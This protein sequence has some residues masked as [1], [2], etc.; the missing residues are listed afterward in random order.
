[1]ALQVIYLDHAAATPLDE[2]VLEAMQPYFTELF[3]NP[4]SPYQP[5]LEVRRA[6][7]DAKD[8]IAR[9]IG[10]KG[11]ELVM[12]AGATESINLAFSGVSGHVVT[13]NIE[14]D[15]VLQAAARHDYTLVKSDE[16]G[17]VAA[18]NICKAIQPDTQLVSIQLANNELGTIQ[19]L[20]DIAVIVRE[21]RNR[22]L[23]AG[24]KTP[25]YLH[26]DASQGVGYLDINVARL[27]VDLLTINS[28]KVYGPKQVGLLWTA[29]SVRLAPQ[30]VGGGQERG[31]R[32]GT[33]N[34]AGTIGF[35]R[36]ME[37]VTATQKSESKRVVGLR[38]AAEKTLV[39][40]FPDAVLSGHKKHRLPNFLHIS[41][42]G[43]DAERLVF[44]LE[45]KGLLVATG[46]ACA[47]N[48]GTRSHVL[49]AIGLAPDIADGSLRLSFGH[50]SNEDNTT[51]AI[52]LIVA[53]VKA[54]QARIKR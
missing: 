38:D 33:E 13:S 1:M 6:Y 29:R 37:L 20:R 17:R 3:Y 30:I 22:R 52:E 39:E 7:E 49:T 44:T 23:E 15:A 8:R 31:L 21:E 51:K 5:A 10:G 47:A 43:I 27:G 46:S 11:D 24:D 34:V 12:T 14:H 45:A 4:S 48:K 25:I 42:A 16:R 35:A 2:R 41:F 53:T 9:C 50:L 36:A 40:A 18:D 32:S 54:E 28:G 26:T 19:P